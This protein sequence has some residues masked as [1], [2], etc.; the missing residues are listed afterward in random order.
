LDDNYQLSKERPHARR[1]ALLAVA[2][3]TA[4]PLLFIWNERT[5]VSGEISG[6]GGSFP[7]FRLDFDRCDSGEWNGF[8]GV[9]LYDSRAEDFTLV[10]QRGPLVTLIRREEHLFFSNE[11][12]L[13]SR[14]DLLNVQIERENASVNDVFQMSG[15]LQMD[16]QSSALGHVVGTV[17]FRNCH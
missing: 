17:R 5:Q 14:C 8:F 15:S 12:S 4:I 6:Q 11:L 2:V 9:T 16:C 1:W 13:G 7:S 3:T 10:L